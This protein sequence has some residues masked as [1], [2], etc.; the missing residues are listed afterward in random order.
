LNSDL[1]DWTGIGQFGNLSKIGPRV[2]KIE[3]STT[4]NPNFGKF[5]ICKKLF[6]ILR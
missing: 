1:P 3:M 6:I 4:K 5:S 2:K